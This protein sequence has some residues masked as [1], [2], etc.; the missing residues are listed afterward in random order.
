MTSG[1]HSATASATAR[2]PSSWRSSEPSAWRCTCQLLQLCRDPVVRGARGGYVALGD[3]VLEG[4]ALADRAFDGGQRDDAGERG[5][6]AEQRG[7]GDR[8]AG[9]LARELGGGHGQ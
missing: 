9:V 7:V 8:P 3:G 1:R 5:E 6:A 2:E 4:E